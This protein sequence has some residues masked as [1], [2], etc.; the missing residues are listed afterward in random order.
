MLEQLGDKVREA[1]LRW[2]GHVQSNDSASQEEK[3][4]TTEK[5]HECGEGGHEEY[6]RDR[7][8][9]KE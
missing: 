6:Q 4:K 1:K 9:C 3:R 5:F 2:F 7:R 8:R